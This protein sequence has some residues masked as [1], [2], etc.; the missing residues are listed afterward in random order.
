MDQK[1]TVVNVRWRESVVAG[2]PLLAGARWDAFSGFDPE[3]PVV[4]TYVVGCRRIIGDVAWVVSGVRAVA[5][6][7]MQAVVGL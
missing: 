6:S 7:E 2:V 5:V 4:P 1:V 3:M